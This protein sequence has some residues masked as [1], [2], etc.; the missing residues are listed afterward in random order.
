MI[1]AKIVVQMP[2][3]E[4]YTLYADSIDVREAAR[5]VFGGMATIGKS[6]VTAMYEPVE[7]TIRAEGRR[8]DRDCV[9]TYGRP[10]QDRAETMFECLWC[11]RAN[12]AWLS[13]G[14]PCCACRQCGGTRPVV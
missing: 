8:M 2:G 11:G 6:P 14:T 12:P 3:G 1:Q 7:Y 9:T 13:D 10:K 4:V 5:N